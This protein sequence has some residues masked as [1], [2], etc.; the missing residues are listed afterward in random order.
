VIALDE[1]GLRRWGRALG[2]AA[3]R[4]P[5][6]VALDGPLGAGKTTLVQA[7]C[8]GLG[9]SEAVTSPTFTLVN[10]YRGAAGPVMHA[11]LYRIERSEELVELGWD[12]L[13]R[14]DAPVFVEWAG[15]AGDALPADRWE[16]GLAIGK[17]G[18][19][20]LVDARVAGG[21]PPIPAPSPP[22]GVAG[23][24]GAGEDGGC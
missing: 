20:R 17:G 12:D 6:F 11:D 9:V 24:V 2:C 23:L 3:A 13:L 4:E 21:A 15:R 22:R 16:I 18:A 1:A 19:T 10:R 8:A 5:V 7:A 14:G